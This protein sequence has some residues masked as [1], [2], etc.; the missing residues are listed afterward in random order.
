MCLD[1]SIGG[2]GGGMKNKTTYIC[3][4]KPVFLLFA[5]SLIDIYLIM[6]IL[7]KYWMFNLND[8][9]GACLYA[10]PIGLFSSL[11]LLLNFKYKFLWHLSFQLSLPHASLFLSRLEPHVKAAIGVVFRQ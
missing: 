10:L 6:G 4:L 8:F 11:L 9:F 7:A 3:F 1:S 2:E 5:A